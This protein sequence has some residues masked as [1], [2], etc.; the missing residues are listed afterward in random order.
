MI[1]FIEITTLHW[2]IFILGVLI[3]V[4]LDLGVFHRRAHIVSFK[5]ALAWT[6]V[7]FSTAMAFAFFFVKP[8]R[9][10]IFFHEFIAGYI[11]ELSL[12]LDNVFVIAIIFAYFKVPH[13]FQHRVLFWGILGA[14]IMRAIM[15][16]VGIGLIRQFHAV[17]YL[18]GAFLIFSGIKLIFSG[19]EAPEPEKNIAIRIARKFFP[20]TTYYEGQKFIIK[21]DGKWLLTP[22]MLVLLMVETTDVV[23]ALDSIPAIFG[24][25]TDPF[26]VFTSNVFAILGLRSLYFV[27][28][29]AIRYFRYLQHGISAILVFIG[30]KLLLPWA[31]EQF[32]ILPG[33]KLDAKDALAVIGT[34]IFISIATSVAASFLEKRTETDE[35]QTDVD[36]AAADGT[37]TSTSDNPKHNDDKK[38]SDS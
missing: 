6:M 12:S 38:N 7:W 37:A 23:F 25:T 36:E 1:G 33:F 13:K 30:F 28:A 26:T 5:E 18:L 15:I 10:T 19:G 2:V 8:Y 29:G 11:T 3:A 35:P 16:T 31:Q 17:L 9:G 21:K 20:V 24:I 27:L 34:I 22:M 32:G 4:S 14:L